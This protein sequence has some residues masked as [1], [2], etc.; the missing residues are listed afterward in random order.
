MS[1]AR[2]LLILGGLG[3][4]LLGTLYGLYYAVFVEHQALGAMGNSLAR[5]FVS[6]SQGN[7]AEGNLG[8]AA[9]AAARYNYVRQV[10]V[11][12][13][14]TGLAMLMIVL[15]AAFDRVRL[16]EP[17]RLRLAAGLLAGSIIF[18]AGVILQ[19]YRHGAATASALAIV[20]AALVTAS[21][22][23]TLFGFLRSRA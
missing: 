21:L 18:P 19:T 3:L 17:T 11:H 20:G 23:L 4:A 1:P 16:S 7:V 15:G 8:I 9:Y 5:A 13:H 22:S 6:A 14:W 10:D 2:K 12:S